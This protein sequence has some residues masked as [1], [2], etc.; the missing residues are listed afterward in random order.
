V[1]KEPDNRFETMNDLLAELDPLLSTASL[2]VAPAAASL[3][4][5]DRSNQPWWRRLGRKD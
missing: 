2:V 1:A 4:V 3:V 5:A